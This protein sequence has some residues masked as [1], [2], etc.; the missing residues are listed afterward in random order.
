MAV[1]NGTF[2]KPYERGCLVTF[3]KIKTKKNLNETIYLRQLVY[4]Q[5]YRLILKNR[6]CS[7]SYSS[8]SYSYSSV[9]ICSPEKGQAVQNEIK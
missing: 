1:L 5:E 4:S 3:Q 2:H 8:G 7:Y 9:L 6:I